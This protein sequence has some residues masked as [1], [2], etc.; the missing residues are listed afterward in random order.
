MSRGVSRN[1]LNQTV[2]ALRFFYGVTLDLAE[3]PERI[4]YTV[5]RDRSTLGVFASL[6]LPRYVTIV[7]VSDEAGSTGFRPFTLVA[8]QARRRCGT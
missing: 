4:A 5:N 7:S 1:A 8:F 6:G 3:I 2:R